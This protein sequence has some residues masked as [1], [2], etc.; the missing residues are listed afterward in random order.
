[1]EVAAFTHQQQNLHHQQALAISNDKITTLEQQ[2]AH[3]T[4]QQTRTAQQAE[5]QQLQLEQQ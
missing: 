5:K 1:M 3:S 4:Q 2:L